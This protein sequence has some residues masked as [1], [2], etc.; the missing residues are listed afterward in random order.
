MNSL[1]AAEAWILANRYLREKQ[2]LILYANKQIKK[3]E[4]LI[5]ER[6][7]IIE[8]LEEK[9]KQLEQEIRKYKLELTKS[10]TRY[11]IAVLKATSE[12]VWKECVGCYESDDK[13]LCVWYSWFSDP[14]L[15]NAKVK[16]SWDNWDNEYDILQFQ[17]DDGGY[18]YWI[19]LKNDLEDDS[20]CMYKFK[21]KNGDW[22][23]VDCDK[24]VRIDEEG[25]VNYV[26]TVCN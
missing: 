24:P 18:T 17:T 20:E 26:L 10:E 19:Q 2:E 11:K 15:L 8:Q 1:A 16:G 3:G 23:S 6:D 25:N 14:L 5:T 21:Y 4:E 7:E 9:I 22:H 12:E 13:T